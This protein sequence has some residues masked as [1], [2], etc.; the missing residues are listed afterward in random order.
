ML[1]RRALNRATLERQLLLRRWRLPAAEAVQQLAG[2][3]AQDP[4]TAYTALWARL[5]GFSQD[6]LTG[7][8]YDRWVVR[9]SLLR[10]TQHLVSAAD[11]RWLRPTVQPVLDR[12]RQAG[13][14]RRTT[15]LD[16]AEL[17]AAGRALL[18]GRTLTRQQLG[19][20][21]A[22]RWPNRDPNAL[23]WSLQFLLPLVH[24]PPS[25]TW[26]TF[27]AT[28][29]T[30]A[31]DW[32]GAPLAPAPTPR[33]LVGR[34]LAAFGPA[35]VMDIQAWSGLTRLREVV[36]ALRPRLRVLHDQ[37]GRE[38]LDLPDA[39]LPDPDTPAPPRFLPEVDNLLL[40]HADR[41][42][43]M[44]DEHRKRVID[45]AWVKATVLVDGFVRGT[46]RIERQPGAATL[47][48][49]L[50]EAVAE[51]DRSALAEEGARLLAFAAGGASHDIQLTALRS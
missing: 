33:E 47:H 6:A 46:W 18:A 19:R 14:G 34:Y 31:E 27:G 7:L 28:P 13:F 49:E 3:N 30:L 39:A 42:R 4:N 45:G 25:G 2:L 20:L 38:L 16:L 50:F 35:T 17:A 15:G 24:P 26:G 12:V 5:E 44:T 11:F 10:G 37:A 51:R 23:A 1:G 43:V 48:V 29:F 41:R 32:L 36:E 21:L 22:E 40:A 9:S 8:L